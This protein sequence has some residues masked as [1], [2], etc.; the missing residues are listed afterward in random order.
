MEKL[1]MNTTEIVMR[2]V[3]ALVFAG[4]GYFVADKIPRGSKISAW[5]IFILGAVLAPDI[6]RNV[7]IVS[8]DGYAIYLSSSLYGLGVGILI[9]FVAKGKYQSKAGNV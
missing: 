3:S 7:W 9:A 2:C 8:V 4:V 6:L 1:A 5:V